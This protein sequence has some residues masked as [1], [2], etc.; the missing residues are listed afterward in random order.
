MPPKKQ[1]KVVNFVGHRGAK[2]PVTEGLL[3]DQTSTDFIVQ[4]VVKT[5]R[6]RGVKT[7]LR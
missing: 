1:A 4:A 7:F 3:V 2:L 5:G 6:G